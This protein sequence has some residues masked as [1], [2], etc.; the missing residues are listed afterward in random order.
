MNSLDNFKIY[1]WCNSLDKYDY[2]LSRNKEYCQQYGY[3]YEIFTDRTIAKF[4]PTWEKV[5]YAK[6]LLSEHDMIMWIDAD[7]HF[8]SEHADDFRKFLVELKKPLTI[9]EDKGYQRYDQVNAGVFILKNEPWSHDFL[10]L[11]DQNSKFERKYFELGQTLG[12]IWRFQDQNAL[13]WMFLNNLNN[14]ES[15]SEIIKYGKLQSFAN[16]NGYIYHTAG[17]GDK[18]KQ[19]KPF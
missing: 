6:K 11:W 15:N 17:R 9:S 8:V 10:D 19:I 14:I 5:V 18:M 4:T 12:K 2:W 1:T 3:D 16:Y 7:A 13:R